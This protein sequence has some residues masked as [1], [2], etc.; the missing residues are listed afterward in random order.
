MARAERE[1]RPETQRCVPEGFAEIESAEAGASEQQRH[2]SLVQPARTA[3]GPG[4]LPHRT[5][6]RDRA[7]RTRGHA[8]PE[9]GSRAGESDPSLT[10]DQA[11]KRKALRSTQRCG[12]GHTER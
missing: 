11:R 4:E 9:V 3:L 2:L 7:F 8:V 1:K 6:V 5:K 12:E 10:V